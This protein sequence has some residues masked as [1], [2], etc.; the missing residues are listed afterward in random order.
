MTSPSVSLRSRY[1]RLPEIAGRTYLATT[2]LGRLPVAMAPLAILALVTSTSG[3]VAVGGIASACAALGEALGVPVVGALA[4]RRGQRTVLLGVVA[5]HLLA[6]GGL[7]AALAS[8]G[9]WTPL[10]AAG[11]GLTLPSVS[12][13]SRARWLRMTADTDERS[14]AFAF[15][16]TVDEA[17][18]ILGPALVGIV[19]VLISPTAA[20][21]ATAG[22]SAVFVSAFACHRSHRI[23]TPV[24]NAGR[25]RPAR[26]P[27]VVLVPVLAMLAMGAVFGATQTGVTAAAE[28]VGSPST[29]S[30]VYALSAIGS[31]ATTVCLVLLPRSFGLRARWAVCGA[32]LLLGAG[33]MALAADSLGAL[34]LAVLVMG[35]FVG[36]T[37]VTVNTIA[38]TLVDAERGAFLMALLSSGVVLGIATG[39]ALGGA[40][41]EGFGPA[42]GFTV[43]AAAAVLLLVLAPLAPVRR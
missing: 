41:A 7:F 28:A 19:G 14:T 8:G 38:A 37:L 16:G 40:L 26:V 11:V 32:G 1:S 21:L 22:L 10:A 15:E 5:L 27:G 13:F 43:V 24:R 12:G 35:V 9:P 6:L 31:T 33:L 23:T 17:A 29:G 30:L 20:L 42:W 4:D 3:S 25:T 34:S 18:F 39:A 2:A 36:P